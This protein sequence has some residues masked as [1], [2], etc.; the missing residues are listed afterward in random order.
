MGR[1][2]KPSFVYCNT[3][4][5]KTQTNKSLGAPGRMFILAYINPTEL[6]LGRIQ[7][8]AEDPPPRTLEVLRVS[9]GRYGGQ[10]EAVSHPPQPRSLLMRA[11]SEATGFPCLHPKE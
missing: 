5:S 2:R 7:M 11:G 10:K 1:E 3:K 8:R 9:S 4:N 6:T